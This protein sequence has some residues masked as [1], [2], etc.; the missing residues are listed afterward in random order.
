MILGLLD[1]SFWGAGR[2]PLTERGRQEGRKLRGAGGALSVTS[3]RGFLVGGFARN[4]QNKN[5]AQATRW[6]GTCSVRAAVR[7]T[8]RAGENTRGCV[9]SY[10]DRT[11]TGRP[12]TPGRDVPAREGRHSEAQRRGPEPPAEGQ[13]SREPRGAEGSRGEPRGAEG[14]PPS[15]GNERPR[16]RGRKKS[17]R[18]R[19]EQRPCNSRTRTRMHTHTHLPHRASACQRQGAECISNPPSYTHLF[20]ITGA[21]TGDESATSCDARWLSP[22]SGQATDRP[23]RQEGALF[24]KKHVQT[25]G[26]VLQVATYYASRS[27]QPRWAKAEDKGGPPPPSSSAGV[28]THSFRIPDPGEAGPG[29]RPATIVLISSQVSAS[30]TFPE[31]LLLF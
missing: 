7:E 29:A 11:A 31:N 14:S 26:T 3:R 30:L 8:K 27:D 2:V 22:C 9:T 13:A 10:S 17:A 23:R 20:Y 4:F 24:Q 1:C 19:I 25:P 5:R 28:K 15:H 6:D 21:A 12:R 18:I 16:H